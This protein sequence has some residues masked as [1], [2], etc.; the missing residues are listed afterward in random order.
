MADIIPVKANRVSGDVTSLGEFEPGDVV[1]M[2][3]G[4][5]P[6]GGTTGQVLAKNSGADHDLEWV[7]QSGG[8]GGGGGPTLLT[9][10]VD[11][12]VRTDGSDSNNGLANTSGGAFLTL[13]KAFDSTKNMFSTEFAVVINVGAG[14]FTASGS[15]I[16]SSALPSVQIVGQGAG[17]TIL[18]DDLSFGSSD[19]EYSINQVTVK[20]LSC[21]FGRLGGGDLL[22]NGTGT[23]LTTS[24]KSTYGF[25]YD[26]QVAAGT[27]S[28]IVRAT[29]GSYAEFSSS[30]TL[31]GSHTVSGAFAI[32]STD[33][34]CKFTGVT[35]TGTATGPRYLADT[36][37]RLL[38]NG[39][40]LP[41]STA[42]SVATGG[43]YI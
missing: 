1:P 39:G 8:G 38:R 26:V 41:G 27:R 20:S 42:G 22:L 19:C 33:A 25:F 37:G 31:N 28:A 40:N 18:A 34:F 10:A 43:A 24:G 12:Y 21:S 11:F 5:I 23:V 4:G 9:A 29:D 36:F 16:A 35:F 7:D 32:V 6:A 15:S 13:Q 14:T 30:F 17:T 3:N 2:A